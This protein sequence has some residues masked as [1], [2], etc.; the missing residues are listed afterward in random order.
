MRFDDSLWDDS[1]PEYAPCRKKIRKGFYWIPPVK[2]IK[3]GFATRTVKLDGM[4]GDSLDLERAA[5]CRELTREMLEWYEGHT[6]GKEPGTWAWLISRYLT[7]PESDIQD[8]R[9]NTRKQYK[10]VCAMIERGVGKVLLADT[11]FIR[12]KK[13]QR[14]M[15][16]NGR[17][18]SY[19]QR[20]FNHLSMILSYGIKMGDQEV[21]ENCV[22]I[23]TI[24][25]EMSFKSGPR[26]QSFIT[27]DEVLRVV[28]EADNRGWK[29][30][31]LSVL[32][33]FELMLRGVDVNGQWVPAEGRKGG[34]RH[35]DTIWVD[36][37]TWDNISPDA[38]TISKQISKTR[39][40]LPEPYHF[41]LTHLPDLR[42]RILATP[43]D[44]RTGPLI[45]DHTGL[46][47]KQGMQAKR[48]KAIIRHLEMD[49][50]LQI[51]DSRAGG[52]T[53]AKAMV[54]PKTLQHAAQHQNQNTT[55]IYTRDRSVSANK[56]IEMRAKR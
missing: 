23:K 5:R 27:R 2:Y 35:N 36:G 40:S 14:T 10:E 20:W 33:R 31:S 38:M 53:E 6:N 51:R 34:I 45:V 7:D 56:V 32:L 55:D 37:L 26:R 39:D 4:V 1:D 44:K 12:M 16:E 48:F 43:K 47:P 50:K 17:S 28:E 18:R 9:P 29:H 22:R 49:D 30:V 19:I 46:P 13:W 25:G 42:E 41:D 15:G 3:A 8:V 54:D 11:D 24:R 21:H 52:I